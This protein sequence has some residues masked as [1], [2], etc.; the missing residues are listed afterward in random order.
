MRV[1]T[2]Y[3][4]LPR[5]RSINRVKLTKLEAA[6]QFIFVSEMAIYKI[7]KKWKLQ[8]NLF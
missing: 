5:Q 2:I 3:C 8:S 7:I 6:K 1:V 4:R